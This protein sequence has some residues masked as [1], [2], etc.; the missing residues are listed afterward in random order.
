[1]PQTSP[2]SFF[3]FVSPSS[4]SK[5]V[6]SHNKINRHNTGTLLTFKV[7]DNGNVQSTK[8]VVGLDFHVQLSLRGTVRDGDSNPGVGW[9]ASGDKELLPNTAL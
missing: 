8:E 4:Y 9:V 7:L 1:M 3:L 6:Y 2:V 5:I